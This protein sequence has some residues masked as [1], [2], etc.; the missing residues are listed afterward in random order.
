MVSGDRSQLRAHD[1]ASPSN[2]PEW[3]AS[4]GGLRADAPLADRWAST[5]GGQFVQ[6]A[7][8][9]RPV[10]EAAVTRQDQLRVP[11][12]LPFGDDARF[13]AAFQL[14]DD[15]R[16]AQRPEVVAFKPRRDAGRIKGFARIVPVKHGL[17][18]AEPGPDYTRRGLKPCHR[19]LIAGLVEARGIANYWLRAGNTACVN[20]AAEFLR[21]TVQSLP[22]TFASAWCA[23]TRASATPACRTPVSGWAC[24]SSSRQN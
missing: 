18:G 21:Q 4:P 20:G 8:L 19:P 1:G 10:N 12:S 14:V 13:R 24:S 7:L 16:A 3:R 22:P 11:V 15:Q 2:E 9:V 23:G 5:A 6:L 17:P